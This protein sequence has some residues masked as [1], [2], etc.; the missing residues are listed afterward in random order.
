LGRGK[1]AFKDPS[2]IPFLKPKI[3][4]LQD[5]R[6]DRVSVAEVFEPFE[7]A[8]GILTASQI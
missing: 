6:R 4:P 3:E 8:E 1:R 2:P 7:T 5:M